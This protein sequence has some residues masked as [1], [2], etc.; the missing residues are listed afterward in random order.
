[1]QQRLDGEK[2]DLDAPSVSDDPASLY[3]HEESLRRAGTSPGASGPEFPSS[4][5]GEGD[6]APAEE[7]FEVS[8]LYEVAAA[9]R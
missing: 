6:A 9:G 8:G 2:L 4:P 5:E 3:G 7:A 1:M